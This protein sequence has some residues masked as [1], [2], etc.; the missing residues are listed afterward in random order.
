MATKRTYQ[1][2]KRKSAKT[3]GF[4]ARMATKNGRRVINARRRKG[5]KQ[6]T[7]SDEKKN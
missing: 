3:H 5:R 2:N 1:P 6:L 4:R 7:V